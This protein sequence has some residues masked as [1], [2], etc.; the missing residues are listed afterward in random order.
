MRSLRERHNILIGLAV[1]AIIGYL[2][3][4]V[5]RLISP[6]PLKIL[7]PAEG[8]ISQSPK[9][10]ILGRVKDESWVGLNNE[11]ISVE[12]DGYFSVDINL[13]KGLNIIKIEARKR[14]GRGTVEYRRIIVN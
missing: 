13:N 7:Y 10:K 11:E 1:A 6:P 12:N 9:V 8:F 4:Q 5:I 3:W 14:H 2:G